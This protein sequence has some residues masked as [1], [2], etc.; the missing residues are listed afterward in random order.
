[1]R[2]R[3]ADIVA[4]V[5]SL[6]ARDRALARAH[7]GGQ[8]MDPPRD[9]A[10]ALVDAA[11]VLDA[12]GVRYAL[13]GG[14]A[15]AIHAASPRATRDIDLAVRSDAELRSLQEAYAK[16]GFSRGRRFEHTINLRH[17]NGQVVQLTF[18]PTFDP[19]IERAG[20]F[21]IGKAIVRLVNREDLIALK[22]RAAADPARRKSKALRDR[23]DA[24]LLREDSPDP[25][26]G[27]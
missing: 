18:D 4:E 10:V 13:V 26:E 19:A 22:E 7:A 11:R 2:P 17:K 27:W 23:A 25:E 21:R 1:M 12:C 3:E 14:L 20:S 6:A 16:A 9:M 15:V 8:G 24:E 5:S